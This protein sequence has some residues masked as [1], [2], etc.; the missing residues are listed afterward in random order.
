M[1]YKIHQFIANWQLRSLDLIFVELI[2][3]INGGNNSIVSFLIGDNE[4][5]FAVALYE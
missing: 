5:Y 1:K 3:G 2:Y 4:L